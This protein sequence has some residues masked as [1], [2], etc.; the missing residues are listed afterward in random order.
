MRGPVQG[1]GL[2]DHDA[3]LAQKSQILLG[4]Y[5]VFCDRD[6]FR[7]DSALELGKH[8]LVHLSIAALLLQFVS[9]VCGRAAQK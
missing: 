7:I 5:A 9:S 3:L 6:L 2:P 8:F 4:E 1:S